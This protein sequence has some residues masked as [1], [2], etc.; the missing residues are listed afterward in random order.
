MRPAARSNAAL[1]RVARVLACAAGLGVAGAQAQSS[2]IDLPGFSAGAS[3]ADARL[4]AALGA[5]SQW[6]SSIDAYGQGSLSFGGGL[7]LGCS[8]VDFNGF[9]H[10]FDPAELLAEMRNSLLSGAQAAASNYL[11]TLAYANPTIASVLDMMDKRYSARFSA[12]SQACNA[13]AARAEGE[14]AGARAMANAGDECFDRQIDQGTAPTEAYRRCSI[15]H[16]F[17]S[18]DIPATA[19]TGDFLRRYTHV[20]VT[21]E[22]QGLLALLPDERILGGKYQMRPPQATLASLAASV[23]D[24]THAALNRI[25]AGTDPSSIAS[26]SVDQALAP[27]TTQ[28][29]E[30]CIPAG[31]LPLVTSA[32]FRSA[33][34]LGPA[35]RALFKDAVSSQMAV[36]AI[37][38]DVLEL[39]Q[40]VA[41]IDVRDGSN[42]DAAYVNARRRQIQQAVAELLVQADTQVKAQAAR[43]QLVRSQ[44]AA[45]EAVESS[46]DERARANRAQREAPQFSMR[47]LLHLFS[48]SN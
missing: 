26:C 11:I 43:A 28:L 3:G 12:F 48:G 10:S 17:D 19:S 13:Q 7:R 1:G 27:A 24:Q 39:F 31:M 25:D 47:D 40:Q 14:N 4:G 5:G 22:V 37:Y 29:T 34:L 30:G 9:L 35:A 45:L 42:A 2:T 32:A 6:Q 21:R 36:G 33:H 18:L 38:S 16:T 41:R 23:R 44:I 15:L 20:N 46:L 8:G